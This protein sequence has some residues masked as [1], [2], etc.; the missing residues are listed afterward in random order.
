VTVTTVAPDGSTKEATEELL[1]KQFLGSYYLGDGTGYSLDLELTEGQ[2]FLCTWRGCLGVYGTSLGRWTVKT[3]GLQLTA[4]QSDGMLEDRPLGPLRVISLQ[5]HLLLL[6]ERDRD[7]F[8][9]H[10]A[11]TYCCFHKKEARDALL[12]HWR[13]VL[14]RAA[15]Q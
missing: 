13:R 11:D 2:R 4:H 3:G 5:G 9:K 8:A 6:Q 12:E 10:G 14:E 1:A 7:W 15:A